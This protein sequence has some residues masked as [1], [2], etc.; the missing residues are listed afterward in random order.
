[1]LLV[2]DT[3]W[4]WVKLLYS[5]LVTAALPDCD[6]IDGKPC[7]RGVAFLSLRSWVR[8]FV[9]RWCQYC[10]TGQLSDQRYNLAPNRG[11]V[12]RSSHREP[13]ASPAVNR[14]TNKAT[15]NS[16]ESL[17]ETAPNRGTKSEP[18]V[19]I[20]PSA[21]YLTSVCLSVRCGRTF[22]NHPSNKGGEISTDD[23]MGNPAPRPRGQL[24]TRGGVL[25]DDRCHLRVRRRLKV[26]VTG[27]ASH[28][29]SGE[30]VALPQ[31]ASECT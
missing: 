15:N 1:M 30:A 22:S 12:T 4:I 9:Y 18:H 20:G 27:F 28:P 29:L 7:Q 19:S 6:P 25:E 14:E 23:K 26:M 8:R 21:R 3:G 31:K 10:T 11:L 5:P 17:P 13:D 2:R 16:S 24:P